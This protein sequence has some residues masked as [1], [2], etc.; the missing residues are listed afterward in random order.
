MNAV[1]SQNTPIICALR[2][3]LERIPILLVL[4]GS[5]A[6]IT[7]QNDADGGKAIALSTVMGHFGPNSLQSHIMRSRHE[8]GKM[9]FP[10]SKSMLEV[11]STGPGAVVKMLLLA[12]AEL[13]AT[14][15]RFSLL[16]QMVAAAGDVEFLR[17]LIE[18]GVE[19]NSGGHYYGCALQ[20]AARFGH[21]ECVHLLLNAGAEVNLVGVSTRQPFE[22][23]SLENMKR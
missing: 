17:L 12:W 3:E 19:V 14:D 6:V 13:R 18:R 20:A 5:G 22:R 21:L 10:R 8:S 9:L 7:G 2:G 15:Q 16:Q 11:L 4:L 23:L 1:T